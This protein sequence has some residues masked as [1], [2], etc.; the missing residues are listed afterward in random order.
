MSTFNLTAVTIPTPQ[1]YD[2]KDPQRQIENLSYVVLQILSQ[3][4]LA[5]FTFND[6]QVSLTVD[7][8][9]IESAIRDLKYNGEIID[10]GP[11]KLYLTGKTISLLT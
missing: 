8:S 5:G 1:P 10:L 3:A 6:A 4:K 7:V 2:D 9:G 11:I